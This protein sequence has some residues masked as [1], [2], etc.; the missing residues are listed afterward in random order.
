MPTDDFADVRE[1]LQTWEV[2]DLD[3]NDGDEYCESYGEDVRRL[4]AAHD[5]LQTRVAELEQRERAIIAA[6]EQRETE[7][8]DHETDL[9]RGRQFAL[10]ELKQAEARVNELS[11]E[12]N[13]AWANVRERDEHVAELKARVAELEVAPRFALVQC[14]DCGTDIRLKELEQAPAPDTAGRAARSAMQAVY[15]KPNAPAAAGEGGR[16]E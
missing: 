16:D 1:R 2:C 14:P 8:A 12:R 4:L 7:T 6:A 13:A 10:E 15:P 3:A 5:A 11:Q 9:K